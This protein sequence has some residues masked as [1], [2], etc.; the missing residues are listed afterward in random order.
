MPISENQNRWLLLEAFSAA[1]QG[2]RLSPSRLHRMNHEQ[3]LAHTDEARLC[4][5]VEPLPLAS[6]WQVVEQL[7]KVGGPEILLS[8]SA[9]AAMASWG[10]MHRAGQILR[11]LLKA[12]SVLVKAYRSGKLA[13]SQAVLRALPV[14]AMSAF[15]PGSEPL[16]QDLAAILGGFS[17]DVP[18]L[19]K[20][21]QIAALS[22][23]N[24]TVTAIDNRI[25]ADSAWPVWVHTFLKEGSDIIRLCRPATFWEFPESPISKEIA[26]EIT[27]WLFRR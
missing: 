15:V 25:S 4:R 9:Q 10:T 2:L 12:A 20:S 22:G 21:Y 3:V 13:N 23:G 26:S 17:E 7:E 11:E 8:N 1:A 27:G 16:R 6:P 19:I 14:L 18:G 24:S 5:L